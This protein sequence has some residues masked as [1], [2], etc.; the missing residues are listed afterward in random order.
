MLMG[1]GD[2]SRGIG[3]ADF[4]DATMNTALPGDYLRKVDMMSSAHGLEVRIPF[5]GE[6]VLAC[7][8]RIPE[9]FRWSGLTSGI[10]GVIIDTSKHGFCLVR[11]E[12]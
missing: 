2:R 9:R 10:D 4:I 3:G 6:S 12:P 7:S 11:A 5:L 8:A 1:A